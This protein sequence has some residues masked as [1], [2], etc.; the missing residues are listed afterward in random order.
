MTLQGENQS[1]HELAPKSVPSRV[2]PHPASLADNPSFA[3]QRSIG[4][5]ALQRQPQAGA[6][7]S[8]TRASASHDFFPHGFARMPISTRPGR[9][10]QTK[11]TVNTP[12][13]AYEQEADRVA[14]H[15]M[16]M[17]GPGAAMSPSSG[18]G[19][20][21]Q[22]ACAGGGTGDDCK[23]AEETHAHVQMKAAGPASTGAIEAPPIVH[24]VLSSPGQPL[25][26]AA[27]DFMEP[28]FGHDFS[29]VRVHTDDRAA[30]SA[31][32]VQARAY[33]VGSNVVFGAGAFAPGTHE[34]QK[35]LG[36]E[37]AHVVQQGNS[38]LATLQRQPAGDDIDDTAV[39]E[40]ELQSKKSERAMLARMLR[41]L[42]EK[43]TED[44]NRGRIETRSKDQEAKLKAGAQ[45]GS[46]FRGFMSAATLELLHNKT[47][48][49][50]TA[51]GFTLKIR[52]EISYEGLN[53]KE[54]KARAASDIPRIEKAISDA[55]TA[56]FTKG[57]FIGKKFRAEPHIKFRSNTDKT[58]DA[59]L[60]LIVRRER[61]G[62]SFLVGGV[63]GMSTEISFNP[64][65]L[66]G[67][68]V[69]TAAHELYHV[70]GAIDAYYIPDEK[71]RK[72]DPQ[73]AGSQYVVGRSDPAGRGDLL[74]MTT[75]SKLK[76]WRDKNYISQ[77]DYERQT[78]SQPTVWE[79]DADTLLYRMGAAPN[80]P[81][82][83]RVDDPD[84][85]A[86]DPQK[87]L[88]QQENRAKQKLDKLQSEMDRDAETADY[89]QKAERAIQLDK[90]I[91]E[92]QRRITQR[93]E[94]A[95]L[96]RP[97]RRP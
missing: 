40:R 77:A 41:D 20:G 16:R 85:P 13:D 69:I 27:R 36:H 46:T 81:K 66:E 34:G 14:D 53:D 52:F 4:N 12:G 44:V 8:E 57:H 92:L 49:V 97:R 18:S 33:A 19:A 39:L 45:A 56:N 23:H 50:T 70:F 7:S 1:S 26:K 75:R 78:R 3:L 24:E 93:K 71:E 89:G 65:H 79:E 15:V 9:A 95:I 48:L 86:F 6:E 32:A 74:G 37:L 21:L 42:E 72:R 10:L 88:R 67:D 84:S 64:K 29:G 76:E 73:G 2:K 47:D 80:T 59:A 30:E 63:P 83:D 51:D 25:D 94:G 54:G 68:N 38:S 60:Q 90:E 5:Q 22:R 96:R 28:R 11:L 17:P 43:M 58:G 55:W 61:Q 82:A 35:L 31:S 91:A 87:A 62:D